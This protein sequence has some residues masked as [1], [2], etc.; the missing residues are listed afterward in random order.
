MKIKWNN[1]G[2]AREWTLSELILDQMPHSGMGELEQLRHDLDRSLQFSE[3][4]VEVLY[5]KNLI[6]R[7]DIE[8]M[9]GGDYCLRSKDAEIII[10]K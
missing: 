1:C 7:K 10:D 6:T 9:L 4:L 3:K 5:L 8:T 2:T